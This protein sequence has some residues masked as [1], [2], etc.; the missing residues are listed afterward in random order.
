M[1][2]GEPQADKFKQ[3]IVDDYY[4]EMLLGTPASQRRDAPPCGRGGGSAS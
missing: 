1:T 4:F 3:A 2:L